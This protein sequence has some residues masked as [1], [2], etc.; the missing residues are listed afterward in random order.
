LFWFYPAVWLIICHHLS[1]E[2]PAELVSSDP[3]KISAEG[4][5][6]FVGHLSAA[7]QDQACN[8]SQVDKSLS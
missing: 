3:E 6:L 4:Q 8:G 2:P 7:V 1:S 5:N